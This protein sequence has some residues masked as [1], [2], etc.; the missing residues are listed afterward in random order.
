MVFGK[1][2]TDLVNGALIWRISY[3]QSSRQNVG[4][5]EWEFFSPNAVSQQLFA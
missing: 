1:R 5:I 4:E 3:G 2:R